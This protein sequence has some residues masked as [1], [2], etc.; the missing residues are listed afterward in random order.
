[1]E[2]SGA[3]IVT[4]IVSIVLARILMPEDYGI[5]SLVVV[6][7]SILQVFVD[8]GLGTALI[9]KK[10]ADDLDFSSVF[11]FNFVVCIIL[12]IVMFIVAPYI[13]LFYGDAMLTPIIRVM[14]L[15][16]VIS[17]LKGIQQAYVSKNMLFKRFFF[18]T[19]GGT[20][21]SAIL[22]ISLAYLG[23]GV[24]ALVIQQLSNNAIDTFILWLTVKW[25]PKKMF[26]WSRLLSLLTFGWK[27]LVSSLLDTCYNNIRNLIIGKMYSA[28][29]LAYYNQGDKFPYVIVSNI[30][31]SIDSVLLPTL[32][33]VQDNRI[34]VKNMTRRAIKTSTYIM[35]PLMMGLAFCAEPVV[36]VILTDK[37]LPCVPFLRIFCVT[38]M[39]WPIHTANLNAIKAMGRS[40]YFLRLEIIKKIM[41]TVILL[42]TMWFGVKA[43]AY[44]LLLSGI[45]S[46]AINAYPNKKLLGYGY[47]DQMRDCTLGIILAVFMGICVY[48]IG[49]IPIPTIASLM[50]QVLSG[51]TCSVIGT[52]VYSVRIAMNGEAELLN[53]P[54][55]LQAA[56]TDYIMQFIIY[57]VVVAQILTLIGAAVWYGILV[58]RKN[59]NRPIKECV[60]VR[61]VLMCILAGIGLQ[62]VIDFL[63]NI[64]ALA[65]PNAMEAYSQL[66]KTVGIG[67]TTWISL[68]ATVILAP[69]SE[70]LLFRGLTLRFLRSAGVKF[71][72]ANVIQALFF[73]ILHMNLVQGIYAF[74]VGLVLGYVAGKCRT[75][76]LPILLHLC[77]NIAGTVLAALL[78][79]NMGWLMQGIL[80]VAGVLMLTGAFL[81][82]QKEM[83]NL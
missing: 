43:M 56:V 76:F 79:G 67:E 11:Y 58:K 18:S 61:T 36:R 46:Q 29:D 70:E 82:V 63:L 44:S 22:G 73:G 41:G 71:A 32:S 72:A 69:I 45:L 40:D 64:A 5:I 24:W 78:S 42:S 15:T 51:L 48:F 37:W 65:F 39:F 8:S 31:T 21:F 33:E 4:F 53:D 77:F 14:S 66:V 52:V 55:A 57:A 62:L 54:A 83:K 49:Y 35:A 25:R 38:Y 59:V 12:Y 81:L 1:M 2:R 23:Y 47:L 9:Q 20:I 30:N 68:L 16:I 10:D 13:S 60:N 27:L 34:A 28:A 6:F 7:T 50:I 75:V 26:S 17:G 19:I 80:T 3:Q 74:A